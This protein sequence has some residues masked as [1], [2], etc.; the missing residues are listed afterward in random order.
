M[1]LWMD[2]MGYLGAD[3]VAVDKL[4]SLAVFFFFANL[5]SLNKNLSVVLPPTAWRDVELISWANEVSWVR[6]IN[7]VSIS[8]LSANTIEDI[9]SKFLWL[10]A[11][12]RYWTLLLTIFTRDALTSDSLPNNVP[13]EIHS[14]VRTVFHL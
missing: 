5:I 1:R 3:I 6:Y 12:N 4:D 2:G 13:L 9:L 14:Q 11:L 8:K 10:Q 7:P